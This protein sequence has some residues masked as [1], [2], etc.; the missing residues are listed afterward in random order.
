MPYEEKKDAAIVELSRL[1]P[2]KTYLYVM[3]VGMD[4]PE[5]SSLVQIGENSLLNMSK[6][7]EAQLNTLLSDE[8]REAVKKYN[9]E[10]ITYREFIEKNGR[11][12]MNTRDYLGR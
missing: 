6:N 8:F 9:I 11:E 1:E 10:L 12:N 4:T 2:G 5:M 7:R 3:H